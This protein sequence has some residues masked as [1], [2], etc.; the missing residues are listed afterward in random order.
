MTKII[1]IKRK[2][3]FFKKKIEVEGDKSLRIRFIFSLKKY[4]KMSN[5]VKPPIYAPNSKSLGKCIDIKI[6]E[7]PI[8]IAKIRIIKVNLFV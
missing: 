7:I 2:I 1:S 4:S 8:K 6:L 5:G 3:D